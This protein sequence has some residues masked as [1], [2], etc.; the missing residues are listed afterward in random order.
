MTRRGVLGLAVVALAAAALSACGSMFPARY[1]YRMTVEVMTP[2]G[3]RT[4]SAVYEIEA[5]AN[6]RLLPEERAGGGAFRGQAVVVDLPD[7][8][9]FVLM[10]RPGGDDSLPGL[11]TQTL[12]PDKNI[13]NVEDYVAAVRRLG[14]AWSDLRADLPRQDWPRMIRFGDPSDPR[15]LYDTSPDQI[16]VSRIIIETTKDKISD[17]IEHIIPWIDHL[18]KYLSDRKNPFTS[19][20]SGDIN[21]LRS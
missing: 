20:I 14:A 9:L 15:T 17:G 1:R 10:R 16:G 13:K 18:D 11:V 8:P 5:Y 2:H 12:L 3:L 19:E 4:G 21:G 6:A 7:G